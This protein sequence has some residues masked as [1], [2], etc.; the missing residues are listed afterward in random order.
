M[1]I[2]PILIYKSIQFQWK[3]WKGF[4]WKMKVWFQNAYER[5]KIQD[6]LTARYYK[7]II[8]NILYYW[9]G[10]CQVDQWNRK[11][12][13]IL[14]WWHYSLQQKVDLNSDGLLIIHREN[15]KF[16]SYFTLYPQINSR[17]RN[18]FIVKKKIFK[19]FW[20]QILW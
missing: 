19:Y 14:Q 7:S 9:L 20:K 3:S 18:D 12:D 15:M 2:L 1:L 13:H 8:I 10:N 17:L 11:K 6:N 5:A 16:H 4:W